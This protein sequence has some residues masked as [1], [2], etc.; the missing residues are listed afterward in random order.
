MAVIGWL[1]DWWSADAFGETREVY[2]DKAG[3]RS[4]ARLKYRL[5]ERSEEGQEKRRK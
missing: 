3:A 2:S 4:G 5:E 1:G